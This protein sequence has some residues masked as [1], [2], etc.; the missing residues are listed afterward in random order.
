M[1]EWVTLLLCLKRLGL[2]KDIRQHLIRLQFRFQWETHLLR[3]ER[4]QML[5][6]FEKRRRNWLFLA[7]LQRKTADVHG[8]T[9]KFDVITQHLIRINPGRIYILVS[10]VVFCQSPDGIHNIFYD[11]ICA[12]VLTSAL[13][14]SN[15]T[16]DIIGE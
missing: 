11:E 16:F 12:C 1:K 3:Q 8:F 7:Q 2:P 14:F 5:A 15:E 6:Q 9:L 4:C 13:E 10:H